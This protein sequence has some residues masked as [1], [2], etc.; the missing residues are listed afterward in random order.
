MA[1]SMS[2]YFGT[3]AVDTV[4]GGSGQDWIWGEA[5]NDVLSGGAGDDFVYG[6]AGVD[7]INGGEGND[8]I[9]GG[10]GDPDNQNTQ[11]LRGDAGDDVI[12]GGANNDELLGDGGDDLL[13]GGEGNDTLSSHGGNDVLDGG[14]GNDSL[15]P[16]TGNDVMT[17]GEGADTFRFNN[18]LKSNGAL[19]YGTNYITDFEDGTDLLHIGGAARIITHEAR[20]GWIDS[21]SYWGTTTTTDENGNTTETHAG[22]TLDFADLGVTGLEGIL[23][24]QFAEPAGALSVS[25]FSGWS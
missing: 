4:T 19:D 11:R 5:G 15:R 7:A 3:D 6:G 14:S 10:A 8:V 17:G 23:H 2:V 22:A 13:R 12:Y 25:D 9:H 24:I 20:Q 16:S 18:N 1:F 21:A